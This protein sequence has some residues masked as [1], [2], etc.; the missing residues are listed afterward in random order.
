MYL[1]KITLTQR[2]LDTAYWLDARGYLGQFFVNAVPQS[3]DTE[4]EHVYTLTEAAAWE[5]AAS[6]E[7][8]YHAFLTC[9]G[10]DTLREKMHTLLNT[11]V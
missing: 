5:F 6:V 11:I 10:S 9:N 4:D 2:E 3:S 8:D 1:Y 7:S